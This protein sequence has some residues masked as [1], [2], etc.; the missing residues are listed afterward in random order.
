MNQARITREQLQD[1][2]LGRIDGPE[3]AVIERELDSD[4]GYSTVLRELDQQVDEVILNLRK[5]LPVDIL[6]DDQELQDLIQ[7]ASAL[8]ET[9]SDRDSETGLVSASQL[10][11][12]P[13]F[14]L[15]LSSILQPPQAADELGRISRYRVM[16]V[17]GVGGMGVVLLAEDTLLQRR[18]ALKIMKPQI[19][20]LPEVRE[21]F[22]REARAAA[23]INHDHIVTV[24]Q[25]DED[26][27][28]LFR[29]M[30]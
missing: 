10:Q 6:E 1:Y 25:V 7:R 22:L 8:A 5:K 13:Q 27:R 17:L 16:K 2:L 19:A 15:D 18:V 3:L 20:A 24:Y 28:V 9:A 26:E 12:A 14:D 29:A 21:R 23:A 4:P 11:A 30:Q